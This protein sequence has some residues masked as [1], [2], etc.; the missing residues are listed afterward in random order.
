VVECVPA[1]PSMATSAFISCHN[2]VRAGNRREPAADKPSILVRNRLGAAATSMHTARH[3][4]EHCPHAVRG[5][6]NAHRAQSR[7]CSASG[8]SGRNVGAGDGL[9]KRY[10]TPGGR[11]AVK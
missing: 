3:Y 5:G 9:G 2:L 10:A 6:E 7:C 8:G 11:E 1:A 4:T